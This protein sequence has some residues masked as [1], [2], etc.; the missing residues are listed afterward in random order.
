MKTQRA[1]TFSNNSPHKHISQKMLEQVSGQFNNALRGTPK[2]QRTSA[3]SVL[4]HVRT[5]INVDLKKLKPNE[6]LAFVRLVQ[7][8]I[9]VMSLQTTED[10]IID[11]F[12][13]D[14]GIKSNS[15]SSSCGQN[16]VQSLSQSGNVGLIQQGVSVEK[17]ESHS[18]ER[19]FFTYLHRD[20]R[21][22][23]VIFNEGEF[24]VPLK[25]RVP[26]TLISSRGFVDGSDALYDRGASWL[27]KWKFNSKFDYQ[28]QISRNYRGCC[29]LVEVKRPEKPLCIESY[30][31]SVILRASEPET[32]LQTALERINWGE[33]YLFV[34]GRDISIGKLDYSYMACGEALVLFTQEGLAFQAGKLGKDLA[35]IPV[36]FKT[37]DGTCAPLQGVAAMLQHFGFRT[38]S[39]EIANALS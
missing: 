6:Q 38:S 39:Y 8:G 23:L 9:G 2:V 28:Y 12:G 21:D 24:S 3:L 34:Q 10:E 20:Y 35:V 4:N 31:E 11:F 22:R 5:K 17:R 26:Y 30:G 37:S 16:F 15:G 36:S 18:T 27:D 32:H 33:N 14:K 19:D 25:D 7:Q 1:S 13:F 29:Y